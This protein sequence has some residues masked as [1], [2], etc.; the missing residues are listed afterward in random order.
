MT[1]ETSG[2]KDRISQYEAS[3][4]LHNLSG[5]ACVRMRGSESSSQRCPD[6]RPQLFLEKGRG[7][8]KQ[9]AAIV[10]QEECEIS[11][12]VY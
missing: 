6:S 5:G 8:E 2:I 3:V 1:V 12:T 9:K 10:S 4:L 11:E 7:A